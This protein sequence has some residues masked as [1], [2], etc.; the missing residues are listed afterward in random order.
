MNFLEGVDLSE[1]DTTCELTPKQLAE[2]DAF[3]EWMNTEE[4]RYAHEMIEAQYRT[5]ESLDK[6]AILE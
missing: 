1:V 2:S 5:Y 4:A 3:W 6:S